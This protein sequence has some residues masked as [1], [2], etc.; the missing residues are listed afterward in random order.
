MLD[1]NSAAVARRVNE[2]SGPDRSERDA[3]VRRARANR[4]EEQQVASLHVVELDAT[5]ELV[6]IRDRSREIYSVLF[7]DIPDEAAAV[8]P[9]RGILAAQPVRHALKT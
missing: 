8:E 2:F 7:E 5:A 1:A 4:R 3:H 9:A 6:L